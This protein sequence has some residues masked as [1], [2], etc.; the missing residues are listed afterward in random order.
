MQDSK[1]QRRLSESIFMGVIFVV[2]S[3][4]VIAIM[5]MF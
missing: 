2:S 4:S 1:P 3:M 5:N